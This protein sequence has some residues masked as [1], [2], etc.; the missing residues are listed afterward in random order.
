[1]DE[2]LLRG[3]VSPEDFT[4]TDTQKLQAALDCAAQKD[5]R[6]VIVSGTYT[7]DTPLTV[8]AQ[9][10]LVLEKARIQASGEF[11]VLTAEKHQNFSFE[12]KWIY[13]EGEASAIGGMDFFNVSHIVLENLTITGPVTMEYCHDVRA[14]YVRFTG[15]GCLRVGSGCFGFILQHL[16][17]ST[18]EISNEICCGD[19]VPGRAPDIHDIIL[20]ASAFET[21]ALQAAEKAGMFNIQADH[22]SGT[23]TLGREGDALP[24]ERYFNLTF[25]DLGSLCLHNEVKHMYTENV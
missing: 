6:K 19:I 4:G 11:P 22:I 23:V 20:R 18:L 25:T 15:T 8:P 1:M 10:H 5:I 17:G 3:Y 2:M 9:T 21:V 12:Q 16:T 7:V 14:E 13:I 24:K